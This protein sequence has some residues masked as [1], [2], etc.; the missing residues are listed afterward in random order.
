[1]MRTE[2]FLET[3]VYSPLHHL[4]RLLVRGSSV[5]FS[6]LETFGLRIRA[7]VLSYGLRKHVG[8]YVCTNFSY[9]QPPSSQ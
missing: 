2:K 1:M 4:K 5:E 6:R 8:L 9:E 3:L 7:H